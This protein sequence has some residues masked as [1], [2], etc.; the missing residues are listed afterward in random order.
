MLFICIE[1]SSPLRR[2]LVSV[3][4]FVPFLDYKVLFICIKFSSTSQWRLLITAG[5]SVENFVLNYWSVLRVLA[6]QTG[7]F[8]TAGL[9]VEIFVPFLDYKVLFIC[10]EFSSTSQRCLLITAGLSVENFVPNSLSVFKCGGTSNMCL[11]LTAGL[12]MENFVPFLDYKVLFICI[13]FSSTSHRCLLLC[14]RSE[15]GELCA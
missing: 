2:F 7:V 15:R 4:N 12:S 6:H 10:I 14:I 8:Y 9:S 11:L 5:L 3:E 13:E 1:F